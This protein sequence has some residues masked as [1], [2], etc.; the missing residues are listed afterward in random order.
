MIW[1]VLVP[2]VSSRSA[3]DEPKDRRTRR[4]GDNDSQPVETNPIH[5]DAMI[6]YITN[7]TRGR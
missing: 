6:K 5:L 1:P 7:T 2:S 4:K 3:C